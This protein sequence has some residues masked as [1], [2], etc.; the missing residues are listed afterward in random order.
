MRKV[1]PFVVDHE[2]RLFEHVGPGS[3]R[4]VP[5]TAI[6]KTEVMVP[7]K[8]GTFTKSHRVVLFEPCPACSAGVGELCRGTSGSYTTLTHC[9]RRNQ[10]RRRKA[11][12]RHEASSSK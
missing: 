7:R 12:T 6:N 8:D 10:W 3:Y 11:A 5:V 9:D 1:H 4:L 2:G